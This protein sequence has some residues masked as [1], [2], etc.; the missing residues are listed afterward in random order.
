MIDNK[1]GL[2]RLQQAAARRSGLKPGRNITYKS[3]LPVRTNVATSRRLKTLKGL[4]P[5]EYVCKIWTTEPQ[6]FTIDP[7]Q[8]TVGLNT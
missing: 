7:Y 8:H 3:R 4:T 2:L 1:H 5:Y 6:R